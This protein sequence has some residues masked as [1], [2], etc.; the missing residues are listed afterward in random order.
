[1]FPS[2]GRV[3]TNTPA[4]SPALARNAFGCPINNA[5]NQP[6]ESVF[7]SSKEDASGPASAPGSNIFRFQPQGPAKKQ[8]NDLKATQ[9]E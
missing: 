5:F 4:Q 3:Q 2:S 1:M 8:G 7:A 9:H 6:A